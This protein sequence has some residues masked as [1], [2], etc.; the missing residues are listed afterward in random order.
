MVIKLDV[1]KFLQGRPRMLTRDVAVA[2]LLV[3]SI[4]CALFNTIVAMR[5]ELMCS[6][7][8]LC[9]RKLGQLGP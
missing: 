5:G 1:R 4:R 8:Q 7:E 3:H 2:N 6:V 9:E